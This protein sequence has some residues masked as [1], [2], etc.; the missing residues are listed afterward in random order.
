MQSNQK[1]CIIFARVSSES[2]SFDEQTLELRQ[3]AEHQYGY[4]PD[5][6]LIIEYKESGI[7]LKE[8]E[9]LGLTEMKEFIKS[10]PQINCVF[11]SEISRIARTKK[12]LFSIQ[13]FLVQRKI[14]LIIAEPR[15][16]LLNSDS[17]IND[18]A[19]FAFTMYAQYAE[20]EMRQ[21]KERFRRGRERSKREGKWN[22]GKILYGFKVIDKRLVPDEQTAPIVRRCFEMYIAGSSLQ[23]CARYL[24][25]F[26]IIRRGHN[27]SKMFDNPKYVDII[28]QE[29]FDEAQNVKSG[30]QKFPGYRIYSPGERLLKCSEC[31][32]HY[33]H[34]TNCYICLG[35][36]K[37]YKDCQS[38]FS[39]SSKYVDELL[40]MFAKYSYTAR[41]VVTRKDDE[42]RLQ[43]LLDEI[44]VKI[45]AINQRLHKLALK[46][47]RVIDLYTDGV[48][49]RSDME[50]RNREIDRAK[51][52]LE[53]DRKQLIEHQSA[54]QVS[55]QN[56]REG[57]SAVDS[58][59]DTLQ[60]ASKREIYELIHSEIEEVEVYKLG[61][62]RYLKFNM[63]A[64]YSNLARF[65]GRALHFKCEIE[66]NGSWIEHKLDK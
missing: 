54:L 65:S 20:S 6:H 27:M 60:S 30:R 14:Q 24:S 2:Q 51:M 13:D 9:R 18:A 4:P 55:L 15:I 5:S 40:F 26:G 66:V 32:R 33:V 61:K 22:G 36:T 25:E 39:I 35:R 7:R 64:G 58:T 11:A 8:E 21:K 49:D 44:P 31:N 38:G 50:R 41:L 1:K 62:F 34:I 10:D 46:E 56:Y 19:D 12:V 37:P 59:L 57:R 52:K 23:Y 16:I 45:N 3:L 53:L 63:K 17:T 28:G 42:K 48:I 29:L 43:N 47:K